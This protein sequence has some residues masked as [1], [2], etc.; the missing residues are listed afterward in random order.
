MIFTELRGPAGT[1]SLQ[2]WYHKCTKSKICDMNLNAKC[3]YW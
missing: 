1:C 3:N 2:K